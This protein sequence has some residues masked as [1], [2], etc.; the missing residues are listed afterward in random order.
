MHFLGEQWKTASFWTAFVGFNYILFSFFNEHYFC[1]MLLLLFIFC[2]LFENLSWCLEI[3]WFY[4]PILYFLYETLKWTFQPLT[5]ITWAS[6][7][8]N[9][10]FLA[11]MPSW[12]VPSPPSCLT[13]S[14]LL[15][16]RIIPEMSFTFNHKNINWVNLVKDRFEG[17]LRAK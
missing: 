3:R 15:D 12:S 2:Y 14:A 11:T 8:T 7:S 5:K 4:I 1:H 6:R 17:E 16:G 13:L 9:T 10:L